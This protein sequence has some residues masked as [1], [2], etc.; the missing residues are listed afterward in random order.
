MFAAKY[1]QL[2]S[3]VRLSIIENFKKNIFDD[4][5]FLV[6]GF[7]VCILL[8]GLISPSFSPMGYNIQRL[9]P[10][11]VTPVFFALIFF[12]FAKNFRKLFIA[13]L[14]QVS[15]YY[16]LSLILIFFIGIFSSA[17]SAYPDK[18]IQEVGLYL[19][20]LFLAFF[21]GSSTVSD[22]SI[23]IF[24]QGVSASLLIY[25]VGYIFQYLL[26]LEYKPYHWMFS[27]HEY[28]NPRTFNHV[29]AWLIPIMALLPIIKHGRSQKFSLFGLSILYFYLLIT[30]G[31]G[32]PLSLI[33]SFIVTFIF[34]KVQALR[35]FTVH[36]KGFVFGLLAYL[37]FIQLVPYLL[38]NVSAGETVLH[39]LDKNNSDRLDLWQLAIKIFQESPWLGIGPQQFITSETSLGSPHNIIF[40]W[41]SEWG[42]PATFI[43]VGISIY[44]GFCYFLRLRFHIKTEALSENAA[45]VQVAVF[46]SLLTAGFYSQVSGVFIT[47]L[48]QLLMVMVIGCAIGFY[49]QYQVY[50]PYPVSVV[51]KILWIVLTIFL[52]IAFYWILY[53]EFWLGEYEIF[54]PMEPNAPRFWL[55][56][57][58]TID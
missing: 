47:P 54:I 21:V 41:L 57:N 27:V 36:G 2:A 12:P 1:T 43:M 23:T 5:P 39:R 50:R 31:R 25:S 14:K 13:R 20:F 7:I 38:G 51:E 42:G 18:G 22:N 30:A 10:L 53:C 52:L 46:M 32:L 29:Q 33:L 55:N 24:A 58:F 17:S 6:T 26:F 45:L 37:F 15:T 40:Q 35:L 4:I 16:R 8:T 48:S 11:L 49:F 9:L 19:C 44:S 3:Q 34:F 56:G 28:S